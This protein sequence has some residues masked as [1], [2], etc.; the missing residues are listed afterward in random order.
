MGQ[1]QI[2]EQNLQGMFVPLDEIYDD[3]QNKLPS[4][5]GFSLAAVIAY[6]AGRW[7]NFMGTPNHQ[8]A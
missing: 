8:G 3:G 1:W 2:I 6:A 4:D 7:F 5:S